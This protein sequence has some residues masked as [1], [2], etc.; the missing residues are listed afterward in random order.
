[1]SIGELKRWYGMF[2]THAKD[3][4]YKDGWAAWKFKEKF[5]EWPKYKDGSRDIDEGFLNYLVH[6]NIRYA[7]SKHNKAA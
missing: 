4:G 3:K 6:L 1:V 7:K 2:I 5:G